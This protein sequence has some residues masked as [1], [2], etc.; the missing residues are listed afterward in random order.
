[1]T[2]FF[3]FFFSLEHDIYNLVDASVESAD[4]DP[5]RAD[6]SGRDVTYASVWL[7]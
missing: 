5:R 7:A 6:A 1:M 4:C 3:F 2:S